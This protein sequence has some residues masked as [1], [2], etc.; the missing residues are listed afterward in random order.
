MHDLFYDVAGSS[1]RITSTTQ[2]RDRFEVGQAFKKK[3]K[4]REKIFKSRKKNTD[5][6]NTHKKS[7][8]K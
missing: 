7:Q 1:A 5:P 8:K 3:K 6:K 4:Q 2:H